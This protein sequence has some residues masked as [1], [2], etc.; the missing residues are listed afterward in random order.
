MNELAPQLNDADMASI[1]S[2][3]ARLNQAHDTITSDGVNTVR[4]YD[5]AAARPGGAIATT[6]TDQLGSISGGRRYQVR[7]GQATVRY[8]KNGPNAE[9]THPNAE[10]DPYHTFAPEHQQKATELINSL[11]QK[12]GERKVD[13]ARRD[14]VVKAKE[15]LGRAGVNI[16][17]EARPNN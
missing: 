7:N 11:A 13:Q 8:G 4:D 6:N 9:N 2:E 1:Q 15:M 3:A 14:A 17:R 10:G 16:P 5:L 12:Q